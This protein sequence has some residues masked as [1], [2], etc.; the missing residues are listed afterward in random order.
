MRKRRLLF[1]L[2][3]FG[4][5]AVISMLFGALTSIASDLPGLENTV[6]FSNKADSYMYDV[7]GNPIGPLAP[8][9]TPAIDHWGQISSN[10]RNAVVSVEDRGFWG[11]SG[12][13]V[14]GLVRAALADL[15]GGKVQGGS[16]IPEEFIKNVRQEESHRTI[17]EKLV[18]AG[19]AFQLSHHWTHKHILTEYLNTIY[20]GNGAIGIEAAARVYF[21]WA[22]GYDAA[23]PVKGA[24]GN[25]DPGHPHR[26]EC[27]S[28]LTPAQ[29]ALLAG[30]VANPSAFNPAG[31][32]EE[33]TAARQRRDLV[34][35]LMYQQHYIS[36]S[37]LQ[38]GRNTP[39]PAPDQI[40]QPAQQPSAAPYFTSW[41]EPQVVQALENQGLSPKQA[42]YEADYGGLRIRLS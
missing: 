1:V 10:M 26:K 7:N 28:L 35:E 29:A 37:Q 9:S 5:L 36:S 13:S 3:A 15:T 11:E 31:T 24:C 20:F 22:H 12:I 8:A 41:V 32:S 42:Q 4:V 6:Q 39:L 2:S 21:G 18:E 25:A 23:N 34:L 30:M 27:A 40:R 19:M 16:T 14:R 38:A 17:A 33:R